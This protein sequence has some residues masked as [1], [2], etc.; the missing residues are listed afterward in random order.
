MF[1]IVRTDDGWRLMDESGK[2]FGESF[3]ERVRSP[4]WKSALIVY[5]KYKRKYDLQ[6]ED[7][8]NLSD[9]IVERA[10]ERRALGKKCS[11]DYLTQIASAEVKMKFDKI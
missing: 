3:Q 7:L 10:A 11:N 2:Q 9:L 5:E 6:H 8:I 4:E 1:S